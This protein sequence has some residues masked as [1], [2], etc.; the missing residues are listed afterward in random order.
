MLELGDLKH[1]ARGF[2]DRICDLGS[3]PRR[4]QV[5]YEARHHR[6]NVPRI[7]DSR[8]GDYNALCLLILRHVQASSGETQLIQDEQPRSPF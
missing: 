3:H 5:R 1:L 6:D 8:L 2:A 7:S 4:R